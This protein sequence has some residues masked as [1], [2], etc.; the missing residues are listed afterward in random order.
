MGHP[1]YMAD[2]WVYVAAE[3]VQRSG[4]RDCSRRYSTRKRISP[5]LRSTA[6]I[7]LDSNRLTPSLKGTVSFQ[8]ILVHD[9]YRYRVPISLEL[10]MMHEQLDKTSMWSIQLMIS[11]LETGELQRLQTEKWCLACIAVS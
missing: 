7:E 6:N 10:F 5:G 2:P 4:Y 11:V 8:L 1:Q 3:E 9:R